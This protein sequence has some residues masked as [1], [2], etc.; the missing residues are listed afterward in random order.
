M[1]CEVCLLAVH[2]LRSCMT[3]FLMIRIEAV[4]TCAVDS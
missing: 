4:I 1:L 2:A 3:W